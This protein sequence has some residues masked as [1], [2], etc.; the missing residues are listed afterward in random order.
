MEQLF[1]TLVTA[2]DQIE[3]RLASD[4]GCEPD[5]IIPVLRNA[6]EPY[7]KREGVH[8]LRRARRAAEQACEKLTTRRI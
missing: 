5:Q 3:A 1:L 6:N 2:F 8:C 7:A 4:L